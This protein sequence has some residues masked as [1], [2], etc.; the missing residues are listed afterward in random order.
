MNK[1]LTGKL[2]RILDRI[3]GSYSDKIKIIANVLVHDWRMLP[4]LYL[5]DVNFMMLTDSEIKSKLAGLDEKAVEWAIRY[6]H[7]LQSYAVKIENTA[8]F[9]YN[10]EQLCSPEEEKRRI[11]MRKA[12]SKL[13]KKYSFPCCGPESLLFHHGLL[14]FPETAIDYLAGGKFIDAGACYGDSTLIFSRFYKPGR[15]YAFEPSPKNRE[16]M[17]T[18]LNRF[19]V[20]ENA[21]E[22]I[23]FGLGEKREKLV[24]C[25]QE[26]PS[27]GIQNGE[28][29]VTVEILTMDQ[30]LA[31]HGMTG[32]RLIK[33]DLEGMGLA[34]LK[35]AEQTIRKDRPL[36]SLSIYHNREELLDIYRTLKSWDLNYEFTIRSTAFPMAFNEITLLGYPAELNSAEE[37]WKTDEAMFKHLFESAEILLKN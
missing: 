16:I 14:F 10:H 3:F 26:S 21:F 33:A 28:S 11:P 1:E 18:L 31:E 22:M 30:Y 27:F 32:I 35:G 24:F 20:P 19:R 29:G 12:Y 36:L 37:K 25:E 8:N 15:I 23:P 5:L 4:R 6:V 34:M 9:F 13:R 7:W 2:G 17:K